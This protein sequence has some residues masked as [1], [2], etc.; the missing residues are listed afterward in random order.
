MVRYPILLYVSL[1]STI[2]PIFAGI[3]RLGSI[4]RTMKIL[5]S[6]LIFAFSFDIITIWWI[7][8]YLI[9]LRLYHV[10]F[11]VECMFIMSIIFFC[12]ESPRM[13]MLFQIL[14]VLYVLFW[15][16]AKFT[17]EP[18]SGLYSLTASI[19]QVILALSAGY[20]LFV[21]IGN[22]LQPLF[23]YSRFWVLL[24]FVIYYAGT[25]TFYA[26]Q[27]ILVH[28]STEDL[29]LAGSINWSLKIIFNILLTIGFLCPQT[30]P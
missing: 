24:S 4:N 13:K 25:L 21:V 3:Y 1:F 28:Y 23:S 14:L 10:Y 2:I 7:K 8:D 17:F 18:L 12:Q 16:C 11:V 6:Y 9:N 15:F 27:G 26:L 22:R 5:I 20:T 30:Q 29:F 19:S